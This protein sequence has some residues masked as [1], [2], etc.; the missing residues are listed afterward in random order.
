MSNSKEEPVPAAGPVQQDGGAPP[1]ESREIETA[2]DLA[3]R[4]EALKAERDD[5]RD[6]L[7]RRQADFENLRR[8]ATREK[9]EIHEFAAMSSIGAL[10]PIVDDFERALTVECVDPEY[11]KGM[12]L[13][14]QRLIE[15]LQ[16]LGLEAIRAEGEK[17]DPH[18]HH[19]VESVQTGEVED[20]MILAE[21]Q[22]GYN[23]RGKLLRP[24]MVKVAVSPAG[25]NG[26]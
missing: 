4:L 15:T 3:A 17:F 11:G 9:E 12:L 8:R 13:I 10:L 7:V 6:R 14:Y 22:K 18:V 20:H 1:A 26:Q 5:L 19:A 25:G 21:L 24:A 2:A 23:F 16:K